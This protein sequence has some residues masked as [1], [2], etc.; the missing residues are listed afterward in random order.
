VLKPQDILVAVY[1]ALHGR[2]TLA[3]IGTTLQIGLS[4]THAAVQRAQQAQILDGEGEAIRANL[5][6]LL[7]HGLRYV[8]YPERGSLIRGVPT[9]AAGPGFADRLTAT[10]SNCA[11]WPS[12]K[13]RTRGLALT[14]LYPSVPEFAPS[15]PKLHAVLAAI[16]LIRIG[17]ARERE[18]ASQVL[19]ELL[20]GPRRA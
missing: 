15:N 4:T 17:S 8:F 9:A 20:A 16:D 1:I 6:E 2:Q 7:E 18:V 11:V 14:P 10:D 12:P 5:L 3:E 13:G 19:H